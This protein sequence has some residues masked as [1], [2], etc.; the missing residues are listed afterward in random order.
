MKKNI[1]YL[2]T[3]L[4]FLAVA[5]E[6]DPPCIPESQ[7]EPVK[8]YL[9]K[10]LCVGANEILYD[11]IICTWDSLDRLETY[12]D[13]SDHKFYYDSIGRVSRIE[14]FFNLFI[15]GPK[16]YYCFYYDWKNEKE[17]KGVDCYRYIYGSDTTYT[18]MYS[19]IYSYDRYGRNIQIERTIGNMQIEWDGL[20]ITVAGNSEISFLVENQKFD[21]KHSPWSVFPDILNIVL[22]FSSMEARLLYN[23]SKNN[24]IQG[25]GFF[26]TGFN[27][28]FEYDYDKDGYPL[29]QYYLQ[30]DGSK[31][32]FHTFEY[33]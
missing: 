9:A 20:N 16:G 2:L 31:K 7:P 21:N 29:R 4:L 1:I 22:T 17:V 19:D 13:G 18:L 27:Y 8:K 3:A 33:Y 15:D 14:C 32:L 6:K 10:V 11:K 26:R 23:P 28:T 5:C 24:P 25:N 12:S 30:E